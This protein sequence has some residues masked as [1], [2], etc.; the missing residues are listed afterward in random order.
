MTTLSD[1]MFEPMKNALR[2]LKRMQD[3]IGPGF[4]IDLLFHLLNDAIE[5]G[6]LPARI[7]TR[8]KLIHSL[9]ERLRAGQK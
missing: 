8:V 1:R 2:H 7:R 6:G 4:A 3:L 9:V 5:I